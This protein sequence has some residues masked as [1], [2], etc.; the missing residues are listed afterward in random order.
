MIP[1]GGKIV[2]GQVIRRKRDSD[3]NL[4]GK[5]STNPLLDTSL[6]DVEFEDGHIESYTANIIAE[7]MY[8]QIDTEGSLH[9]LMDEI[10]DHK[11]MGDAVTVNDSKSSDGKLRQTTRG[12]KLCVQ[13]K[14][15]LLTWEKLSLLKDGYPLEVAEYAVANKLGSEPACNWWVHDVLR[16]R[17][18]I[19]SK[20]NSRYLRREEKFGIVTPKTVR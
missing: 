6:F 12:W 7:H 9:R 2:S 10:V 17:D 5:S 1:Q 14:E 19:L 16:R 18:R 13:W 11:R 15:G 20:L 4:I 8:E 3:G